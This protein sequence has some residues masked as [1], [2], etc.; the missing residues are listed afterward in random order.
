[1][2][3]TPKRAQECT[4]YRIIEAFDHY[5][6]NGSIEV[7]ALELF[8]MFKFHTIIATSEYDL[9]RAGRLRDRL[10]L[11]GQSLVSTLA[12]RDKIVIKQ[13]VQRAGLAVPGFQKIGSPL[14][15]YDFIRNHGYPVVVKPAD[16]MGSTN[17]AVLRNENEF[18]DYLTAGWVPDLEVEK[19][20][21]GEEM[22]H[23]DGLVLNGEI[24]H[25]WPSRYING[26]LAFQEGTCNGSYLLGTDNPS[27]SR[28]IQ[29][30][31]HVLDA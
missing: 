6:I 14:D 29:F 22:Y 18:M 28:L 13:Q 2:L 12:F 16:G 8:E 26:C 27:T 1:M 5:E 10:G 7:R 17:T 25:C 9:I 3:T 11:K 30:V 20:I 31:T 23:I 21:A 19:F 24:V 15:L 4:N